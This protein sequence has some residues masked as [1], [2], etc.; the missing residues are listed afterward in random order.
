MDY[1][2]RIASEY[3]RASLINEDRIAALG[4]LRSYV[5]RVTDGEVPSHDAE[6]VAALALALLAE[7]AVLRSVNGRS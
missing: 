7:D 5:L 1:I 3:N 4:V 2:G 6:T